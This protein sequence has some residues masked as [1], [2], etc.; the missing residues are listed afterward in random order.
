[1]WFLVVAPSMVTAWDTVAEAPKVD[2][3]AQLPRESTSRL[4]PSS[5]TLQAG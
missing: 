2:S 4:S 1:M 5:D 3:E